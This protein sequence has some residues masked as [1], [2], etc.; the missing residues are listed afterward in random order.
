MAMIRMGRP[1]TNPA[2][3]AC[4]GSPAGIL[5]WNCPTR[6]NRKRLCTG[7]GAARKRSSVRSVS[8]VS[9]DARRV[10]EFP[11]RRSVA[12]SAFRRAARDPSGDISNLRVGE[13]T[14]AEKIAVPGH[15]LPR[16]HV[17]LLDRL[18][19]LVATLVHVLVP[20]EHERSPTTGAVT[21]L[22]VLLKQRHNLPVARHLGR[23]GCRTAHDGAQQG[24]DD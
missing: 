18:E 6:M 7:P 23:G 9:R 10:R 15:G 11:R 17:P 14:L 20:L 8:A 12:G 13:S 19:D 21:F 5:S 1:T 16:W 4:L 24:Q 2:S 3:I 22:A